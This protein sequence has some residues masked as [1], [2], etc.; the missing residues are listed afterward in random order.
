[1]SHEQ[2]QFDRLMLEA[3]DADRAGVFRVTPIDVEALVG[4]SASIGRARWYRHVLVGLPL[5]ACIAMF[6]GVATLWRAGSGTRDVL[7]NGGTAISTFGGTM[8][9]P[10]ERCEGME[11]FRACFHGPG[12]LVDPECRCVDFDED[13]DVDLH[14]MGFFQ[15][16]RT[17][18]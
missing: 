14:D 18:D 3:A 8:A 17:I 11:N 9:S 13:G 5:A 12:I 7:I 15:L 4:E 10:V 6:F 16:N 1:M 2:R